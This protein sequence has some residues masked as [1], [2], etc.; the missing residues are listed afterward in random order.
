MHAAPNDET[1]RKIANLLFS[2]VEGVVTAAVSATHYCNKKQ[3]KN[4]TKQNNT[5]EKNRIS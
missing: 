2:V 3:N 1:F 4:K 5:K